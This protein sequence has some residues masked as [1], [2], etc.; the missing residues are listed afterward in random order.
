[1]GDHFP[2]LGPG[3]N[4]TLPVAASWGRRQKQVVPS[5]EPTPAVKEEPATGWDDDEEEDFTKA[6][7]QF[8]DLLGGPGSRPR[9]NATNPQWGSSQSRQSHVTSSAPVP[10]K[11]ASKPAAKAKASLTG[12]VADFPT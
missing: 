6:E 10:S 9:Q 12:G 7:E 4:S 11:A 2:T 3:G 1:M 8:P 5:I